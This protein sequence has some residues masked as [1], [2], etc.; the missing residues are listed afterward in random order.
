MIRRFCSWADWF[1]ISEWMLDKSSQI[2]ITLVVSTDSFSHG[3]N[4]IF[5]VCIYWAHTV[6][7]FVS[8]SKHSITTFYIALLEFF[9]IIVFNLMC[10]GVWPA[11]VCA[12]HSCRHHK[13]QKRASDLVLDL[14]VVVNCQVQFPA[15]TYIACNTGSG[16]PTSSLASVHTSRHVHIPTNKHACM[17]TYISL[18]IK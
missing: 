7:H 8:F 6:Y 4:I 11:H 2:Q 16:G 1:F 12:S 14:Q 9:T 3:S 15:P 10:M 17:H 5:K 13:R 18:K